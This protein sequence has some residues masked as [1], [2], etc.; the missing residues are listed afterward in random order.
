MLRKRN[1][2]IRPAA[3]GCCTQRF[4]AGPMVIGVR[5]EPELERQLDEMGALRS[6]RIEP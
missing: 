1:G 3:L 4:T 5:M 6:K 2:S